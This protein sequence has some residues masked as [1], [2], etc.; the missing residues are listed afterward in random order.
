MKA[1]MIECRTGCTCCCD[2]NHYRGFYRTKEDAKHRISYYQLPESKFWP[3][4]SQFARRGNYSIEEAEIEDLNDGRY[5]LNDK[6][7]HSLDFVDVKED[8]SI[9]NNED[10]Y[11]FSCL[12]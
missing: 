2:E 11:L 4:A 8:G 3:L 7:L 9:E 1:Y 5:I 12:Y 6:I 10:E